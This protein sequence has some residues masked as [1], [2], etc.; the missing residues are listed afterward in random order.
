MGFPVPQEQ[1]WLVIQNDL[2][3]L[4]IILK[5]RKHLLEQVGSNK[6]KMIFLRA[7]FC[8]PIFFKR[9]TREDIIRNLILSRQDSLRTL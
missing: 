8:W 7:G 6:H 9:D 3:F 4:G 5:M 2:D 1:I